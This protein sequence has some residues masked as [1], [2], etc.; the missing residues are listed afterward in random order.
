[1]ATGE[2]VEKFIV[3]L[4]FSDKEAVKGLRAF[5]KKVNDAKVNIKPKVAGGSSKSKEAK[6]QDSH[7]AARNKAEFDHS[8]ALVRNKIRDDATR[9]KAESARQRVESAQSQELSRNKIRDE[10]ALDKRKTA[11][12][13]AALARQKAIGKFTSSSTFL[14]A[15]SLNP[16]T[17]EGFK[18]RGSKLIN[19]GDEDGFRRLAYEI[20][21]SNRAL[22]KHATAAKK[23][24]TAQRGLSDSTKHLVRSYVSVFAV[25]GATNAIN[26]TGQQFEALESAMLA[27]MGTQKDAAK[28]IAFLD[29]LTSRLGISLIDTADQYTKFTFAAK[30]KL[31][32]E[33]VNFLFQSMAEMG[34]VL[35]VSK[36]RMKLSF[37]AIQQMMNKSTISSEEL[38]RQFAE[39]MPGGIQLFANAIGK[40]EKELFKLMESG[41]LLAKDVLPK[42]AI[43]MQK[44]ANEAGALE[45]KY[46]TTRVAQGRFFKQLETANNDIFEGGFDEGAA[47]V[48]NQLALG[49]KDSEDSLASFGQV[50]KLF[51]NT[52]NTIVKLLTP[53]LQGLTWTIGKLAEITNIFGDILNN[54]LD[55]SLGKLLIGLASMAAGFIVV[56]KGLQ[57]VAGAFGIANASALGLL[58]TTTLLLARFIKIASVIALVDEFYSYFDDSRT[59]L[60]EKRRGKQGFG[61]VGED[62]QRALG[63]ADGSS[64]SPMNVAQGFLNSF[65]PIVNVT[66][67]NIVEGVAA[68]AQSA[69]A[70]QNKTAMVQ[71]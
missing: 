6:L 7:V 61:G 8:E 37:T 23:T 2:G 65:R 10:K 21:Q 41:S 14:R 42:V 29:E 18:Q 57:G 64:P 56:K 38:K 35:G 58:K 9:A 34:T 68:S 3:D 54:L 27:A 30:G 39:S 13:R 69:I 20:N 33:E 47:G 36:E 62:Y 55:T 16:T 52:L 24:N 49:L 19:K 17:A 15:Q 70:I 71:R 1:M 59:N 28:Q 5:L 25:L 22:S 53:I 26:K 4:G 67:N 48:L 46:K 66:S 12:D 43:E 40:S 51:F 31:P 32:T 45:L 50:F 63:I 60:E 44:V 11:N